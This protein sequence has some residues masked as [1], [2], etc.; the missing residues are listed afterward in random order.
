MSALHFA[1]NFGESS[2]KTSEMCK[3]AFGEQTVG[4]R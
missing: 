1:L 3:A 4:R 2:I